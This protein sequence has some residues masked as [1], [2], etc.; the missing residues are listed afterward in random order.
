MKT[1]IARYL[2]TAAGFAGLA[3]TPALYAGELGRDYHHLAHEN[4][5][6]RGDRRRLNEDLERGRYGD[7]A[8]TRADLNRDYYRRD[9]Q[10]RDIHHDERFRNGWR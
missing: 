2:F 3:G 7:A 5:E 10:L 8:R 9:Q 6:I 4:A 1:R